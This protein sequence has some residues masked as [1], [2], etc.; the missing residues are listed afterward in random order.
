MSLVIGLLLLSVLMNAVSQ[1][2]LKRGIMTFEGASLRSAP[3]P[4]FLRRVVTNGFV[5]IWIVLLLPSIILW[6]K[7]IA[8]TDLSFAYPFQSLTLL[9]VTLGSI[10]FLQEQVTRK[11]WGGILLIC[12]GIILISHS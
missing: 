11:Q 4:S 10:I 9:F 3:A 8:M 2:S 6:L 12:L 5:L 1:L 7:V